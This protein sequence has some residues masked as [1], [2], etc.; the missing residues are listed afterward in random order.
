[1]SV[2]KFEVP[3]DPVG[4]QRPRTVRNKF[5]RGVHTYTPQRTKKY[6][7]LIQ[8]QAQR[9]YDKEPTSNNI[10]VSLEVYF[11]VPK[12]YSKSRTER[13]LLQIERPNKKPDVDN[14]AKAVLDAMNNIIYQDD[15]QVVKLYVEK[16]YAKE[17]KVVVSVIEQE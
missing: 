17:P 10:S 9:A 5:T 13:C 6:E 14:I 8:M 1:M 3:G 11:K 12:S 2:I 16:Y 4:K 15:K 7:A